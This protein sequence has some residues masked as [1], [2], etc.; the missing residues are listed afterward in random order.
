MGG[1][2]VTKKKV[3]VQIFCQGGLGLSSQRS[4][5]GW[6]GLG[7]GRMGGEG[8]VLFYNVIRKFVPCREGTKCG[9]KTILILKNNPKLNS[10]GAVNM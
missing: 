5:V 4:W 7:W 6:E 10:N 8:G 3:P 1:A 9:N 2:F